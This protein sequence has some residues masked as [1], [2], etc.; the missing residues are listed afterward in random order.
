MKTKSLV[1]SKNI[2]G[3]SRL[4]WEETTTWYDGFFLFLHNILLTPLLQM[5]K[6]LLTFDDVF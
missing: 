4:L 2:L 3:I 5:K 1:A 6:T